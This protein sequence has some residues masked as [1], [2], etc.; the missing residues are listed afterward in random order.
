MTVDLDLAALKSRRLTPLDVVNAV[1]AQSFI[2]PSG[3]AKIGPTEYDVAFNSSPEVLDAMNE[4]P[5]RTVDGATILVRDV[6]HVHD[7][8]EPQQNVVRLDGVRG[9]LLTILK[10]G[11]ASTLDVVGGVKAAMPRILAGLPPGLEVREFADQSVFVRAA[12]R[13]VVVEGLI[14]ALLTAA[15]V[16]L[17]LGS[18][19]STFIIA[20]SI[21]LSVL[22]SILTL[23]ALGETINLMTLGGLALAVGI[24]V[25]DA[26]VTIENVHRHL[27]QGKGTVQ[28]ILDGA[29]EIALPTFVGTLCIAVVFV[30]MFFLTG[31]A[32]YLFVPLAEAVI[33]AVLASYALSRTLVPTLVAWFYRGAGHGQP[34]GAA[35]PLRPW[36]RPL[37]AAQAAFERGFARLRDGHARS[38]SAVLRHRRL[39]LGSALAFLAATALLVPWLGRDFFPSVDT[40]QLRL[41]LRA[42]TGTRIEETARLTDEVERVIREELPPGEVAGIL[43]NIGIPSG[44][45]PLTYIDNGLVGTGDAD[46]LV[47]LRPGHRST[48][49]YARRL[50]SR[51][52]GAFPGTTFYFLPADI[53]S[54]TLNFG[55]PAPFDVQIVGRDQ[56]RSRAVAQRL[57][58]RLREVDGAVDVRVQQPAD[59]PRLRVAVDRLKASGMGLTARDV[60]S[61]L[62]LGLSGSS[63]AQPAYWLNP[64]NGVQYLVNTHVPQVEVDS[65]EALQAFPVGVSR[66]GEADVPLLGGVATIGRT[67]VPPV[68]SHR[69]IQ[70]VIDV[71]GGV[72][73]RDLGGVLDDMA[74]LLAQARQALPPGSYLTVRGQA[75]TMRSSFSGLGFGLAAAVVLAYLLLVINF[76]SWTDPLIIVS[77]LPAALAEVAWGLYL[78]LTPLSVP[79]LLGAIMSLGV[80]TA[81]SVLVVTFARA[82]LRRG[83]DPV[84]SA[85]EAG[86]GR[87]RPVLMT[88]LAMIVGMVPIALGTGDGGEQNAPLGRAVIGGLAVATVATLYLVPAVFAALHRSA[89]TPRTVSNPPAEA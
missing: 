14:A 62:L 86:T 5:V 76:Q 35:A 78:T 43:D 50:R 53:V 52:L 24:L 15:M 4:L 41:H 46:V 12:I 45:I 64:R 69:D 80:A 59:L 26:T 65:I 8:A 63:Q 83:L 57:V 72:A 60:A 82:N 58:E 67:S 29:Q 21:P 38:L 56:A 51:L 37:V 27:D 22:A 71:Y 66:A 85:W 13:S 7:G 34:A 32:R 47:S 33:F 74:P 3:T 48:E 55:L 2:L 40:G 87:L 6:A 79:A 84:A 42:P 75:E 1:N 17:F 31:T 20:L 25:D 39:A 89:A 36:L 19:R 9:V 77:A 11:A 49:G 54:Q 73:G 88:A 28:A 44:G 61:S 16:L 10:S 81:N 68:F 18:W 70:P 23:H 30:P